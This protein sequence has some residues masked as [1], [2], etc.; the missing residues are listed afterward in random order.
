VHALHD[1]AVVFAQRH[2]C[3]LLSGLHGHAL[4]DGVRR[5]GGIKLDAHAGKD[6]PGV[7][8]VQDAQ[9]DK[10]IVDAR[11]GGLVGRDGERERGVC[12]RRERLFER[13]PPVAVEPAVRNPGRLQHAGRGA[14]VGY[15][16]REPPP[17]RISRRAAIHHLDKY[18]RRL[19]NAEQVIRTC[20]GGVS[21]GGC[22]V[23]KPRSGSGSSF[24]RGVQ[25]VQHWAGADRARNW[26]SS[27]FL[28]LQSERAM[29][30][31]L[32]VVGNGFMEARRQVP[33]IEHD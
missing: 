10:R 21:F 16:A 15:S 7:V 14:G 32:L 25:S 17:A 33:F 6:A 22:R 18:A 31:I 12:A 9:D 3:S 26:S 20:R 27:G 30:T 29:R 23:A 13:E 8:G 4:A 1:V 28:R 11:A 19:N 24:V 5:G 2:A